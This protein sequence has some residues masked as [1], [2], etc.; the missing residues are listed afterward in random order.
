MQKQDFPKSMTKILVALSDRERRLM[1][2]S[3]QVDSMNTK[4][5]IEK[6]AAALARTD[7]E[8]KEHLDILKD[9][10]LVRE[11]RSDRKPDES[12]VEVTDLC[13]K[14][15]VGLR[16]LVENLLVA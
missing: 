8:I 2:M 13:D 12:K 4:E 3:I 5:F 1:L 7:S 10:R 16:D 11:S 9:A 6:W 15:V 14:A